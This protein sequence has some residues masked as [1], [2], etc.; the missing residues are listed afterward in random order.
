MFG[1][2]GNELIV[3]ILLMVIFIKPKDI[4][5]V[6]N[7]IAKIWKWIKDFVSEVQE[8]INK[9]ALEIKETKDETN[10]TFHDKIEKLR[11][12]INQQTDFFDIDDNKKT[13]KLKINKK[14]KKN[15]K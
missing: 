1:I 15:V 5:S 4:P 8:Q 6:V 7:F 9:V 10:E 11:L 13:P 12:E 2:S 3:I 14:T